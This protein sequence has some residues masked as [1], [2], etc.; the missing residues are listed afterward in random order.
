MT[1]EVGLLEGIGTARSIRR[2][3][4]DPVPDEDL[5]RILWAATRAPSG[6]N[7][8]PYRFVVL[9]DGEKAGRAKALL[10]AAFRRGWA[11]KAGRENWQDADPG[12]RRARSGRAMQ[13]FVDGFERIPVVI[14]ACFRRYRAPTHVEG[15]SIFPACQN[16][17]LAARALGYGACFSSWHVMVEKELRDLLG[18]PSEVVISLTVTIGRPVGGHGPLRRLPM[19]EVVYDDEWEKSAPWAMD[20]PGSVFSRPR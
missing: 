20:P 12:S 11:E 18:I 3:R 10:G 9:R 6:S 15:A 4:P 16:I 8:Q 7:R 14:L 19:R 5:S 13:A 17:L 1:E 2:Y